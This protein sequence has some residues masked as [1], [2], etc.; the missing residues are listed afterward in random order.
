MAI[1]QFGF[2]LQTQIG[3][4]NAVREAARRGATVTNPTATWVRT[5]LVGDGTPANPGLLA[6]NVPGYDS[7]RQT[8]SVSFCSYADAG[9]TS[10][11]IT[12]TVSYRHPVFFPMLGFATDA[13][14]GTP[15]GAWSLGANAQMRLENGDS[16]DDS[17]ACP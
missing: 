4:T 13:L 17:G 16:P 14:D 1:F 2:V 10:Y 7:S 8:S 6:T 15:D 11:R 12:A 5:Q 9:G 3:L